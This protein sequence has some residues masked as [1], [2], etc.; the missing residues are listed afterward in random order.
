MRVTELTNTCV[1]NTSQ[2]FLSRLTRGS[3]LFFLFLVIGSSLSFDSIVFILTLNGLF[4][5][6]HQCCCFVSFL[7]NKIFRASH[8]RLKSIFDIAGPLGQ[9]I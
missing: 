7:F 3:L 4:F 6:S 8:S 1:R 5:F 9:T 2:R